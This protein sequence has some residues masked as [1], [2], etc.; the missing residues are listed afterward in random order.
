VIVW[1]KVAVLSV[2]IRKTTRRA[3]GLRLKGQL[4]GLPPSFLQSLNLL[5]CYR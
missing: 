3:R 4:M 1:A 2:S 5:P